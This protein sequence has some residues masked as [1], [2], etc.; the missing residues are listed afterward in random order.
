[1]SHPFQE[2]HKSSQRE[3]L[4]SAGLIPRLYQF[5]MFRHQLLNQNHCLLILFLPH[6][7]FETTTFPKI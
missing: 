6:W 3:Y 1:M 2:N 7:Y 4:I 5:H